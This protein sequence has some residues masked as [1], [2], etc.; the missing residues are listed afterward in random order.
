M[1]GSGRKNSGDIARL[2]QRITSGNVKG[3]A[4]LK[5]SAGMDQGDGSVAQG[6]GIELAGGE[7]VGVFPEARGREVYRLLEIAVLRLEVM[8]AEIHSFGPYDSGKRLHAHSPGKWRREFLPTRRLKQNRN[9]KRNDAWP[10]MLGVYLFTVKTMEC[11]LGSW[12][13]MAGL[14]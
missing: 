12:A 2:R 9:K 4:I 3:Q 13:L 6:V 5:N 1:I 8:R 10:A 14:R 11:K 7:T